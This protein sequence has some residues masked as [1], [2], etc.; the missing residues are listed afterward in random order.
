MK[1]IIVLIA[2]FLVIQ[3]S[4]AQLT[5]TA[6]CPPFDTNLLDGKINKATPNSTLGE[7]KSMFVCFTEVNDS[8]VSGCTQVGYKDNGLYFYP[9]RN[10]IEI[11]DNYTGKMTPSLM[12]ANRNNLFNIL[13]YPKLKDTGWDA[14]QMQYGTLILYFNKSGNVNKIQ[15]STKSTASLKLCE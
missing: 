4:Q 15:V 8:S 11:H 5:A 7:I 1:S 14:F 13:G 3:V 2:T 9:G 10:Y 6:V 12:G